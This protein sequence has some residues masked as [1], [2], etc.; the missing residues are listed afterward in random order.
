MRILFAIAMC[1]MCLYTASAQWVETVA[2]VLETP[3]FN[4]GPALNARFFNPHGI[5]VDSS[6]KVYIADRY[7]HTIRLF[8]P[9]LEMVSTFA[10]VAGESGDA[11]GNGASARFNE[12]WGICVT[13]GGVVYVADTKNN[14]IKKIET[15]GTVITVAGS[16]NYGTSNG[17]ALFSTFGNPTG[18]EIDEEGN[19]YVAD[20]LTHIIR[21]ISATGIVTTIA[22]KPYLPG[23]ADGAGSDAQFWRPYGLTIDNQGNIIVADEWNHKIRQVTPLGIVTTLAGNGEEAL[24][25]GDVGNASFNYPWDI[26]VDPEGNFFVADGFNYVIR[27]IDMNNVV[28]TLAGKTQTIGGGDGEGSDA[29]FSGTTAIAWSSQTSSLYVGDAIN[30]IV[31][32]ITL[33]NLPPVTLTLTNLTGQDSLCEGDQINLQADPSTYD[34]YRFFL[35]GT[36]VQEDITSFYTSSS[37]PEG[38]YNFMVESDFQGQT[39]TSNKVSITI[40]A[41]P[42]VDINVVGSLSFFEGDSVVLIASGTGNFLW[43][44]GETAQA[45]TVFESGTYFVEATIEGCIGISDEIIVDVTPLPDSLFITLEGSPILCPGKSSMLVSSSISGNQWLK[46]GWPLSGKTAQTLEVFETGIYQVQAQDADS[47]ITTLSESVEIEEAPIPDFNFVA[48]PRLG[49]LGQIVSF[50]SIGADSPIAYRWDFGDPASGDENQS[51]LISPSHVYESSGS[52]NIELKA[53]DNIGCE[54]T[55]SKNNYVI[56]SEEPTPLPNSLYLPNAFTPNGDGENDVFRIRGYYGDV[57]SM[58]IYNH[59]GELLFQS[60]DPS[61]G[62]NGYR[63]NQPVHSGTYVYLVE[64]EDHEGAKQLSGY[65]TLLR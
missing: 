21:K 6:G 49:E 13:P 47:G 43:S 50:T 61:L 34:N 37:L 58:T 5:A 10:G 18:I 51:V 8:D 14:K 29:T 55:I 12:P 15:D 52:Y 32:E 22:G 57:F 39:L 2:G 25:N 28:S 65:V 24:V 33:D 11:D 64:I 30:H 42:Q 1:M 19:I 3:G 7:N 38:T 44:N 41:I 60:S 31:R 46:D 53:M 4:D 54:H 62:W 56:I 36:L 40:L 59:W 26:T 45:I 35:N 9:S 27:K 48:E 17:P 63:N 23:D 20:H 16:G